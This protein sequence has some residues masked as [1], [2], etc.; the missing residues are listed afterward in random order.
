VTRRSY[1]RGRASCAPTWPAPDPAGLHV[2]PLLEELDGRD[3]VLLAVA[4]GV[5]IGVAV[6]IALA[7]AVEDQDAVAVAREHAS[8]VLGALAAER[9]DHRSAVLEGT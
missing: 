4:P 1:S 2:W 7:A 9:D 3:Q 8:G 5:G 6:A